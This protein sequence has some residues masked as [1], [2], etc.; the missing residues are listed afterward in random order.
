MFA[1]FSPA[2]IFLSCKCGRL[3]CRYLVMMTMTVDLYS[4]QYPWYCSRRSGVVTERQQ[5]EE[6]FNGDRKQICI[7]F[8]MRGTWVCQYSNGLRRTLEEF[9]G[10][11]ERLLRSTFSQAVG[12][13][14]RAWER[15]WTRLC[16]QVSDTRSHLLS[17]P[18]RNE[19][20]VIHRV[21][22]I[23]HL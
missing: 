16:S 19:T 23:K 9:S 2:A 6:K 20:K 11:C 10:V 12:E 22:V 7:K 15:N 17:T 3:L 5:K 21:S 1:C 8:G 18:D 14:S 4:A 13:R